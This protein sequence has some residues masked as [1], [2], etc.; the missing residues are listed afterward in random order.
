MRLPEP[1]KLLSYLT[2]SDPGRMAGQRTG[3]QLL[4]SFG[5]GTHFCR[6]LVSGLADNNSWERDLLDLLFSISWFW[7]EGISCWESAGI[8]KSAVN[9]VSVGCTLFGWSILVD[10]SQTQGNQFI[11]PLLNIILLLRCYKRPH[12]KL[13][14]NLRPYSNYLYLEAQK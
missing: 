14:Y 1:K 9:K 7:G 5:V 2:A 13:C 11:T 3:I 10:Q 12:K 4:E 6:I 8:F